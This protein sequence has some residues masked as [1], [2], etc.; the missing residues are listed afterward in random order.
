MIFVII[1]L[2][3]IFH[4]YKFTHFAKDQSAKTK[5]PDSQTAVEKLKTLVF[6]VSNPRPENNAFPTDDFRTVSLGNNGAIACWE[7][8][9]EHAK[10]TVI[11]FHGFSAEKSSMLEQAAIF[12]KLGYSTLLVDFLGSGGSE[13]NQTTI[14]FFEAKQVKICF[15]YVK[16]SGV[17]TI[18][19][20]GTSMGAVAMM[21]AISDHGVSPNGIIMECPFGSMYKT[22]C[23][24][25]EIMNVP[26]FPMAG[27]LVFWG[28]T[29][30]G[31]WAFGH[32]PINYAKH[33]SCPALLLYGAKD[34]KVSRQEIDMIFDHLR[35]YKIKKVYPEAGH[36]N[37]LK[38]HR[39][40]WTHDVQQFLAMK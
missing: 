28:G 27:L 22:V 2:V 29:L 8:P 18:Y 24:R 21:K 35:G 26:S 30:N 32:N 36:E 20:F 19:L 40:E 10:G 12:R 15:D 9:V 33:V 31:F 1:N 23:A 37:Y 6:G 7:I 39:E 11:L 13:G 4:A 5:H 16:A 14:G 38:K 3:A 25:F 34:D 17:E